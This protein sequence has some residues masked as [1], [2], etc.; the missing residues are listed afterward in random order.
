[1]T[2]IY[3]KIAK[4]L[5]S[6]EFSAF[7]R[8]VHS[9]SDEFA[10]KMELLIQSFDSHKSIKSVIKRVIII[11]AII[12]AL[13]FG[14]LCAGA[15]RNKY[16]HCVTDYGTYSS[17]IY[18]DDNHPD[19]YS[20]NNTPSEI[21]TAYAPSYIPEGY[22]VSNESSDF[23][24]YSV[25][26][27]STDDEFHIIHYSQ[28]LLSTTFNVNTENADVSTLEVNGVDYFCVML[29]DW[30]YLTWTDNSYIF[31]LNLFGDLGKNDALMIAQS[32]N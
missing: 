17:L 29:D 21:E 18:D 30:T 2:D 32:L 15:V 14:A 23:T 10:N 22:V 27:V 25:E 12:A 16:S 5:E 26:Y 31:T 1:M 13:L 6:R 8:K 24:T 28:K 20:D 9:F 7:P 3:I 4:E 11:A 19:T